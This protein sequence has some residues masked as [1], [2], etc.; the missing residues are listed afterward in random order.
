MPRPA[1]QAPEKRCMICGAR[2]GRKRFVDGRLEDLTAF[3]KRGFCSLSCA[4]SRSK[5]GLSRNAYQAR[6]RKLLKKA[7]EACGDSRKL[8][9]HHVDEDW[10]N[11]EPSNVQTLCTFCHHFWHAMHKRHGE[12]ASRLMPALRFPL[13]MGYSAE[14][15][16]CAPSE[17]PLSRKL[18]RPLSKPT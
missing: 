13:L 3:M 12:K 14:H 9:A 2:F 8:H 18:Q 11:N 5:G 17:M 6:A 7:C 10:T 15:L 1:K 16:N 4:N